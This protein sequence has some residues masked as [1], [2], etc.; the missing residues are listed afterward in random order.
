M[1]YDVPVPE[2]VELSARC[3]YVCPKESFESLPVTLSVPLESPGK[4]RIL[5]REKAFVK[6]ADCLEILS[7]T[8]E[9]ASPGD[10]W[11]PEQERQKHERRTQNAERVSLQFAI[12]S[13]T[14]KLARNKGS[15][16]F[17]K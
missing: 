14:Y 13:P 12:D 17:N 6:A 4:V 7:A 16:H 8:P 15:V 3:G 10:K 1:Q 11:I 5:R 9:A 2:L